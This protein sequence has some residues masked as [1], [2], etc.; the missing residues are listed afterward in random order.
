MIDLRSINLYHSY[1][2]FMAQ[3]YPK[4]T[5]LSNFLQHNSFVIFNS[6]CV[7]FVILIL[8]R[9]FSYQYAMILHPYQLQYREG[10]ALLMTEKLLAGDNPYSIENQPYW[11]SIYGIMYNLV[12]LPFAKLF[13]N[14][15]VVHR[16]ISAIFGLLCAILVARILKRQ[17]VMLVYCLAGAGIVYSSLLYHKT[18]TAEPDT[19]GLFCFLFA[20]YTAKENDFSPKSMFMATLILLIGFYTK[21]YFILGAPILCSYLFLFRSKRQGILYGAWFLLF[22][23]SCIVIG[24]QFIPCFFLTLFYSQAV[25]GHGNDL[26][27]SAF[28]LKNFTELNIGLIIVGLFLLCLQLINYQKIKA[29]KTL[30]LGKHQNTTT[31]DISKKSVIDIANWDKPFCMIGSINLYTYAFCVTLFVVSFVI[32]GTKGAYLY[33]H[34]TFLTPFLVIVILSATTITLQIDFSSNHSKILQL[35]GQIVLMI[36]TSIGLLS[37][38]FNKGELKK[39]TTENSNDWEKARTYITNSKNILNTP[40]VTNFMQQ[41]HK[42]NYDN[43]HIEYIIDY[44]DKSIAWVQNDLTALKAKTKNFKEE[45]ATNIATKQFD[46]IMHDMGSSWYLSENDLL[47]TYTKVDS[48]E[49]VMPHIRHTWKTTY[50]KPKP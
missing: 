18:L 22:Y 33:Y 39:M 41:Q 11:A 38:F 1:S 2:T 36:L 21:I 19:M 30:N 3:I 48:I 45:I 44:K 16:A 13:G 43:G 28:Q 20:I 4:S 25:S 15:F 27:Y 37:L 35:N 7:L 17:K 31:N 47:G 32:G 5:T 24:Y 34:F 14:T 6:L 9:M 50:W 23:S 8:T 46:L 10:V 49:L 42:K 12:S 29:E 40:S 26:G